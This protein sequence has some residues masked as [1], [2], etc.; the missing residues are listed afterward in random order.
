MR[1]LAIYH[2]RENAFVELYS[3]D[4]SD[5]FIISVTEETPGDCLKAVTPNLVIA[6]MFY[7]GFIKVVAEGLT[8]PPRGF[9]TRLFK[10]T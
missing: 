1:L 7:R 3:D 10:P 2:Y 8:C 5:N 4:D 6:E 9:T